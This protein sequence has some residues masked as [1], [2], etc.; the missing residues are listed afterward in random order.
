MFKNLSYC[1]YAFNISFVIGY[2]DVASDCDS[3]SGDWWVG[4]GRGQDEQGPAR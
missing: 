1:L 4:R 2:L 3:H